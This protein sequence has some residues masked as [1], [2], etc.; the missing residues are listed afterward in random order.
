M[1]KTFLFFAAT[2][3]LATGAMAHGGKSHRLLGTVNAVDGDQL[4]LTTPAGDETTVLLTKETKYEQA[5]EATDRSALTPGTRVSVHLAEDET[6]AI[7]IK[8]GRQ[9]GHHDAPDGHDGGR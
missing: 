6:T 7:E 5:G 3:L 1:R 8:I 2:F 4:V 9:G